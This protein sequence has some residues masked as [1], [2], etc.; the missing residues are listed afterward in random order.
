MR[1]FHDLLMLNGYISDPRLARELAGVSEADE[2]RAAPGAGS[3]SPE[4]REAAAPVSEASPP[5]APACADGTTTGAHFGRGIT[6]LCST[7][8]S[9]FR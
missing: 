6:T 2:A 8:L 7:A 5:A 4:A 3:R 1:I 9:L